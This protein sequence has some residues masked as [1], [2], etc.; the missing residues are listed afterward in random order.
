MIPVRKIQDRR[1]EERNKD[2]AEL[3]ADPG[4]EKNDVA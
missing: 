1:P 3:V 2:K 4:Q